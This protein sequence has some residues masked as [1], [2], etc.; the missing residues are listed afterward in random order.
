MRLALN[1]ELRRLEVR[2]PFLAH[3]ARRRRSSVSSARCG[4]HAQLRRDRRGTRHQPCGRGTGDARGL[5]SPLRM[6]LAAAIPAVVAYKQDHRRPGRFAGRMQGLMGRF[7]R[8]VSDPPWRLEPWLSCCRP[9]VSR[10]GPLSAARRDQR[11]ADG[12]R[13]AGVAGHLHGHRAAAHRRG[14][15]RFAEDQSSGAHRAKTPVIL[16]LNRSGELYIGDERIRTRRSRNPALRAG[17][18]DPSRIVYVRGDQ[19]ISYAQR[20][21]ARHRQSRRLCQSLSP[22]RRPVR[23][24]RDKSSARIVGHG[25]CGLRGPLI[26]LPARFR[27]PP[28]RRPSTGGIEVASSR[29]AKD[30][31]ARRSRLR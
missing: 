13:N 28:N 19:T 17:R 24:E 10:R 18:G 2:L 20:G 4:D 21:G 5:C 14:A 11:D 30:R 12:R 8:S 31:G 6:G 7:R 9:R 27:R 26:L 3:S 16:S 15:A 29:D 1:A 25:A 23:S 22:P